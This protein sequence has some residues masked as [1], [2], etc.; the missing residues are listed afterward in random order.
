M[1]LLITNEK[2]SEQYTK[3]FPTYTY[4]K[5]WIVAHLDLS[6]NWQ[7]QDITPASE[8]VSWTN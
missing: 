8:I 6:K 7:V 3:R 4:A 5:Q 1:R 2:D